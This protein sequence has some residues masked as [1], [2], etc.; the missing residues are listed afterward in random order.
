M[1]QTILT[2]ME[3]ALLDAVKRMRSE[4][5]PELSHQIQQ[6]A[7]LRQEVE[8]QRSRIDQLEGQLVWQTR[9]LTALQPLLGLS[10]PPKD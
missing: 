5:Q 9:M 2:P 3:T 8:T 1:T 10:L 7:D 4:R 6:I